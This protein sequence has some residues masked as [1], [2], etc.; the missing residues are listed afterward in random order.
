MGTT[1]KITNEA[2]L[3]EIYGLPGEKARKKE[4]AALEKHCEYFITKS[5]FFVLATSNSVGALDA[6]PRGGEPGFVKILDSNTLLFPDAKGNRRLDSLVNI[7]E[8]PAV[9]L[10]FLIPGV[11][12]SLRVNG[13]ATIHTNKALL[14]EFDHLKN[15]PQ[16]VIRV[17]ITQ[18]F[19]HCAKALMRSHLWRAHDLVNRQGVPTMAMM[20]RDQIGGQGEPESQEEMVKRYLDDL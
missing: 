16:T 9:G 6:S 4:L 17:S 10:L 20:L 2:E 19:L 15:K 13:K 14:A 12:E 1:L 7:L 11:D 8:Q 5:P 3:R 18:V